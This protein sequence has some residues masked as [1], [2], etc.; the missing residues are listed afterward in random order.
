MKPSRFFPFAAALALAATLQAAD[1][2]LYRNDFESAEVEKTPA[3]FMVMAGTFLVKPEAGGKCLELPGEPLDTFG[4]LFGPVQ[5]GDLTANARFFGTKAG[6]VVTD[7]CGPAIARASR[8]ALARHS[9][10]RPARLCQLE[11]LS[12]R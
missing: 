9:E 1:A 10:A 5:K 11:D 6:R 12:R 3:D 2:P 7:G 4:L 8:P